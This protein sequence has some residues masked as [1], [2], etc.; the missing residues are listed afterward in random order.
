MRYTNSPAKIQQIM[1]ICK[2]NRQIL[3][4]WRFFSA[5]VLVN[6]C[7]IFSAVAHSGVAGSF[8]HFFAISWRWTL[9]MHSSSHINMQDFGCRVR[10]LHP[11]RLA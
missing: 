7:Y 8:H 10:F 5:R 2:K 1:Q 9:A 6:L 3:A 4:K 11:A